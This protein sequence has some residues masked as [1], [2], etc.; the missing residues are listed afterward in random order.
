MAECSA[1][2]LL[3]DDDSEL[4]QSLARAL[5]VKGLEAKIDGVS[6]VERAIQLVKEIRPNV[7]VIDLCL[8]EQLGVQSG[9]GLVEAIRQ[10][11]PT[12]RILVLTG[13]GGV[14]HGVRA[15]RLGA[16]S[17]LEK[18]A[19][20]QHLV[21]LIRDGISQSLIMRRVHEIDSSRDGSPLSLIVGAG[22]RYQQLVSAIEYASRTA[23]PVLIIGETGTGKG[24]AAQVIHRLSARARK[25]FV[26]Y[27]PSFAQAELVGSELFGHKRGSFTGATEDRRG[28]LLEA[29]GGSLFLDEI[30]ELPPQSQVALLGV[31]QDKRFRPIGGSREESS[32]FRLVAATNTPIDACLESGKLRRDLFHRIAQAQIAIPPLRERLEDLPLIAE[33]VL[34]RLRGQEL[35]RVLRVSDG[36][37]SRLQGHSWPG[38]IRELEGVVE[39]AAYRA[40]FSGR[41]VVEADD[42][43]IRASCS[44]SQ[45]SLSFNEQVEAFKL[46]LIDAAIERAGGSQVRAAE[47]LN[48]D[49]SSMRRILQRR[50]G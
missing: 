30:D 6:L 10:I 22:A 33:H 31:L 36:A 11:E 45:G 42:I 1:R 16:A 26:R 3:V 50:R 46:S 20:A 15:L 17:F 28:L 19:D 9:F 43:E 35:A 27:Q 37:I 29:D 14:E 21:A 44:V 12:C 2:V 38:N 18:P 5:R 4:V 39:S 13:H 41:C 47:A 7:A 32:D 23:Q 40:E 25:P 48:L 34:A 8:D 49:R 24:L